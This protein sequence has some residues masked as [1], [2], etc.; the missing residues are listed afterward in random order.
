MLPVCVILLN[1]CQLNF[2]K[3]IF[4]V[5]QS[6]KEKGIELLFELYSQKLNNYAIYNWKVNEDVSW[7]L[8]YKTIY[9][10]AETINLYEFENEQKFG[11]FIFK[12]F[13]NYLR[14][15]FR[16]TK[17]ANQ[18]VEEVELSN[19]IING[20]QH[21]EQAI[22]PNE[23]LKSLQLELDLLEDWQRIL[24]LLRSQGMTYKEISR[25]VDKPEEQL[26]VYYARLKEQLTN[27][28]INKQTK[29]KRNAK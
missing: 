9:K 20:Y 21:E 27:K 18:G 19:Q 14:N 22:S 1:T 28:L 26:K 5:I 24:L 2:K 4:Q 23:K 13:I 25:Y 15:H 17:T 3:E 6:N 7:D 10:V 8:I 12:I 29:F 16:D 11:S